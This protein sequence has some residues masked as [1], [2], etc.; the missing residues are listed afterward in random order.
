MSE[1]IEPKTTENVHPLPHS[2]IGLLLGMALVLIVGAVALV[3]IGK[4][5][6]SRPLNLNANSLQA[7]LTLD[8]VLAAN[9][10]PIENVEQNG[11]DRKK[12]RMAHWYYY[13]YDVVLPEYL[14]AEAITQLIERSMSEINV[15]VSEQTDG[16]TARELQMNVLGYTVASVRMVHTANESTRTPPPLTAYTPITTPALSIES[17][18]AMPT[19]PAAPTPPRQNPTPPTPVTP[20]NPTPQDDTP[21]RSYPLFPLDDAALKDLGLDPASSMETASSQSSTASGNI[22]FASMNAVQAKPNW[23]PKIQTAQAVPDDA[24][25]RIAII[26]DDG[27]YGGEKTESILALTTDLTLAILP[28]TPHG[29]NTAKRA[30]ALGFEVILH[31]PMD[32][33][34]D[35]LQHEGQLEIEMTAAQIQALSQDALTQVPG[36]VGINNH[37]G[38]RFTADSKAM[39]LFF[40]G[41]NGQDLFFVDSGTSAV[42][43]AYDVA[44]EYGIPTAQRDLFLDNEK[45]E[46]AIRRRFDQAV[47][48]AINNGQA[49]AI[50]HFHPATAAVLAERLPT[51]EARGVRLV[52]VSELVK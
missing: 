2:W 51:L 45:T 13:Q 3:M 50:C 34:D 35:T 26:V 7:A 38:S 20:P 40:D 39:A 16:A 41:I 1:E 25:P 11:P 4:Y 22:A 33:M 21:I 9:R 12:T 19:T 14:D 43:T 36:A 17:D 47:D 28:N 49:I 37:M 23:V 32:N 29:R 10:V 27:G 5:V 31:M 24:T 30:N 46:E 42:S 8:E 15:D 48:I 52:H 44:T 6:A 18:P